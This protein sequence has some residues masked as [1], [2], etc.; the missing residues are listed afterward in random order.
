MTHPWELDANAI[1]TIVTLSR[2]FKPLVHRRQVFP[3]THEYVAGTM[4]VDTVPVGSHLEVRWRPARP[5]PGAEAEAA[6]LRWDDGRVGGWTPPDTGGYSAGPKVVTLQIPERFGGGTTTRYFMVDFAPDTWWAG[7]DPSLWPI[8]NG[9]RSVAVTD[10]S[11]FTT[12]PAWPPDGR[13]YFGPDSFRFLPSVRRPV[14][15]DFSRRTFYEIYENRIYARTEGDTVHV[16][17]WVVLVNGGYD[18]DSKYV[19]RVDPADPALPPGYAGDPVRYAVLN[20]QGLAGSPIGFRL[21]VPWKLTPYGMRALPAQTSMYPDYRPTSVFR[22]PHLAGYWS[23]VRAGKAYAL[24]RAE[25]SDGLLDNQITDPIGLADR[26]DAGGGTE[27]ERAERR[28]ILTFYVDKA[29]ALVRSDPAFRPIEGQ[30][31]SCELSL[32]LIGTDP[33]AYS[34]RSGVPPPGGPST[35]MPIRFRVTLYGKNLSGRDTSW[36]YLNATGTPDIGGPIAA[37]SFRPGGATGNPF[38]TGDLKVSIQVCDCDL[39]EDY[40][41]SGRCVDGVD[42]ATGAVAH[43]ENVI[44]IHY[45]RPAGCD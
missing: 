9:E 17:S 8:S 40:P 19:P 34:L 45:T 28:K 7:P 33:D 13:G 20:D 1:G 32:D 25:D 6:K 29:P 18:K 37:L 14:R 3:V 2:D 21:V 23:M 5:G 15:G 36:T 12:S 16:N 24:A 41:G 26:V 30:S 39:C 22:A 35:Q 42:P 4:P 44:T 38:A 43:P 27:A 31:V 11:S 10:W